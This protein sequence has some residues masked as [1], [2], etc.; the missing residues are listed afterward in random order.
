MTKQ[1][2]FRMDIE[3]L[4]ILRV[5]AKKAG[6]SVTREVHLRLWAGLGVRITDESHNREVVRTLTAW[7]NQ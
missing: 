2:A 4:D 1:T 5:S 7:E 6:H 3:L